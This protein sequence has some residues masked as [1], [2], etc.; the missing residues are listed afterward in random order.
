MNKIQNS[1]KRNNFKNRLQSSADFFFTF[2]QRLFILLYNVV[3]FILQLTF[4]ML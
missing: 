4:H 2:V 1:D 3:L